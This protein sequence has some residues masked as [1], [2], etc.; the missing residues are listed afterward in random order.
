MSTFV[1]C[2]YCGSE[3]EHNIT[4]YILWRDKHFEN[5]SKK[6]NISYNDIFQKIEELETSLV[7][8]LKAIFLQIDSYNLP[9]DRKIQARDDSRKLFNEVD[10][11]IL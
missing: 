11:D 4:D 9:V 1:I 2:P 5:C 10:K 7:Y 6:A 8:L 3:K